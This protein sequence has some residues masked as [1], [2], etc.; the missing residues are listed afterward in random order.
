M[1]RL[2]IG[3]PLFVR[4]LAARAGLEPVARAVAD[5][6][7]CAFKAPATWP[8]R[9]RQVWKVQAG[10]GHSSPVVAAAPCT[11]SRARANRKP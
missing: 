11:S 9:P 7:R 10:E 5:R 6:V 3:V 2:V 8:D 1:R 4:R